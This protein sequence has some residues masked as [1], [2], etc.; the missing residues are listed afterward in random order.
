MAAE[1]R[2]LTTPSMI[3]AAVTGAFLLSIS[4]L[5]V[6]AVLIA[7]GRFVVSEE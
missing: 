2:N 7:S 1:A 4:A 3:Y 6:F 5:L